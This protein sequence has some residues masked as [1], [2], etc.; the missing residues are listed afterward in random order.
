[1]PDVRRFCFL[2]SQGGNL[3]EECISSIR[4]LV[5]FG[6]QH[7]FSNK[8]DTFN[9]KVLNLGITLSTVHAFGL[10]VFFFLM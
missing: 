8:Y 10:A 9:F 3:A 4:T 1:M 6:N 7:L 2:A 5:A